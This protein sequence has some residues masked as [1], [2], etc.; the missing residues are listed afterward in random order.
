MV[1]YTRAD[2]APLKAAVAQVLDLY[3]RLV[4]PGALAAI[5]DMAPDPQAGS[6]WRPFDQAERDALFAALAHTDDDEEDF[7]VV[8]S[9]TPD[10]QAGDHGFAFSGIHFERLEDDEDDAEEVAESESVLRLDFP[11]DLLKSSDPE[12][13]VQVFE[14]IARLF[15]GCS[16]HA[17]MSFIH[18]MTF[19]PESGDEIAKL[20]R[21]YLGFD[22]SHDF[23]SLGMRG[24]ALT[25]QW[26]TLLDEARLA[27]LGGMA[28]ATKALPACELRPQAGG[29]L[30]VR[31]SKLPPLADVNRQTPDI[32]RLPDVARFLRPIRFD[33]GLLVGMEDADAGLAWLAR[34]DER[35]SLDWHNG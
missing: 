25:A 27:E 16:G 13:V 14:S 9:A 19:M 15:P 8:L 10:G 32:G 31:A 22:L 21:R 11:W 3:L 29:G 4:P 5:H 26:L 7:N 30:L 6:E 24:K 23:V 33:D 1:F 35:A 17:G 28:A 20:A 2:Y 12:R 34:L 18:P